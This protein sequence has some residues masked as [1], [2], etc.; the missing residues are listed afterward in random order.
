MYVSPIA[1]D[2]LAGHLINYGAVSFMTD[3]PMRLKS[4]LVTPIYVDNRSLTGHPDAGATS[5]RPRARASRSSASS[6]TSSRALKAQASRMPPL[7]PIV[8]ASPRSSSVSARRPTATT[9]ALKAL[10]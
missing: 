5:L 8:S 4:G 9:A 3:A 7:L 6:S 2:I 1:N 10:Q